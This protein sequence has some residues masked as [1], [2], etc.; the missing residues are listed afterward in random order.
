MMLREVR[1]ALKKEVRKLNLLQET[2]RKIGAAPTQAF[3]KM[4]NIK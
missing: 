3:Q 4:G 1:V 2:Q